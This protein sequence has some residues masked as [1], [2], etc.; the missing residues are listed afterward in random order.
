MDW[1]YGI[2]HGKPGGDETVQMVCGCDFI[3]E[4]P[5]ELGRVTALIERN[6]KLI[7]E[8]KSGTQFILPTGWI[9]S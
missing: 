2:D 9:A 6:G 1:H 5:M 4:V 8:T 7:A 3:C